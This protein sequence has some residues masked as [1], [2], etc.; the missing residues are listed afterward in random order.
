MIVTASVTMK[1]RKI[2]RV[3]VK[4]RTGEDSS[5]PFSVQVFYQEPPTFREL[6]VG[7]LVVHL[8]LDLS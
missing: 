1:Q 3:R 6:I 8:I 2:E 4:T 7:T 5:R